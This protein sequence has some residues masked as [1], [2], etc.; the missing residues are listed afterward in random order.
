LKMKPCCPII[1]FSSLPKIFSKDS[2]FVNMR[3]LVC[4]KTIFFPSIIRFMT[5][6]TYSSF[7][8]C[9]YNTSKSVM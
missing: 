6:V 2:Y 1:L 4:L 3:L 8:V 5:F 9:S 7:E